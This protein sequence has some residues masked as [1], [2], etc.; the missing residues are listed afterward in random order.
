MKLFTER[1]GHEMFYCVMTD[2]HECRC[3][4]T[5]DHE[6]V[7]PLNDRAKRPCQGEMGVAEH[8]RYLLARAGVTA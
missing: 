7:E 5:W 3:G 1:D 6:G 4:A 2:N 8:I